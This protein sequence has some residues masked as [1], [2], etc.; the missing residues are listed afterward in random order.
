MTMRSIKGGFAYFAL[1]DYIASCDPV[2]GS[3]YLVM[4]ALFAVMP[5]FVGRADMAQCRDS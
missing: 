3:V 2:S 4:L 1:A 5:I